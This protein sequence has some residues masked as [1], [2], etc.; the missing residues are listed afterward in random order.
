M[1]SSGFGTVPMPWHE[2][3]LRSESTL[4]TVAGLWT[5]A[6]ACRG[7]VRSFEHVFYIG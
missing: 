4:Q 5:T 3:W 2:V 7:S 1:T 6:G